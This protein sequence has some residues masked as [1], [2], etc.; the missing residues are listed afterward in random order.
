MASSSVQVDGLDQLVIDLERVVARALPETL[1]V[2]RKA[3]INIKRDWAQR[4]SG[5]AQAPRLAA[6]ITD[7]VAVLPGAVTVEVGPDKGRAQGALGNLVEYGSVHNAPRP[8]GLPAL[9]AE[10]PRVMQAL[11]DLAGRL[12]DGR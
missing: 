5:L 9:A 7:D 2:G 11:E 6:A 12:L 10:E 1:A 3:A 8:G 4:W